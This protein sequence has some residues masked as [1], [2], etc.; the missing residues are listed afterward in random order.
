MVTVNGMVTLLNSARKFMQLS[1]APSLALS[2]SLFSISPSSYCLISAA[3]RWQLCQGCQAG[4]AAFC[5]FLHLIIFCYYFYAL[6]FAL[7]LLPRRVAAAVD[8]AIVVTL[9]VCA[10]CIAAS[11][12]AGL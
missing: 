8:G 3:A 11:N 1:L 9:I 7:L 2:L 10:I 5:M 6:C 4:G 12:R